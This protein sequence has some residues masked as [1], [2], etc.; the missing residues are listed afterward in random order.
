[1]KKKVLLCILLALLFTFTATAQER[2]VPVYR[3]AVKLNVIGLALHNVSLFYERS[4]NDHWTLQAGTGYRWGGGLPKVFGMGDLIVSS[5]TTGL[6]GYHISPELRYYFNFCECESSPSGLYTGLYTRYTKYYGDL[7][8]HYWTDT[9]YADAA[10]ASNFSEMGVG[11]Q[12]GYQFI[13]KKRF[14]V[15]FMFAGPRLS[16]YRLKCSI[17]S[18][19]AEE[20]TPIIE[21]EINRRLEWLGMD[22]ITITP[23]AEIDTR[24][25]FRNFRYALA[26]GFMF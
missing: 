19:Y 10:V 11:I 12:I 5:K 17:D 23:S 24:V 7:N 4:L 22:P 18:D 13:F 9:E 8:F 2:S 16:T 3:N 14:S 6:R 15:D 21:E 25:G 26:F 20:L 1:M